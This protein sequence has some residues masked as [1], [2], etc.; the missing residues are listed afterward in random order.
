LED[1][2]TQAQETHN[3]HWKK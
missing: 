2:E 1:H 3:H